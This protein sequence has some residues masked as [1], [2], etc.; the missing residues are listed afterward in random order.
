MTQDLSTRVRCGDFDLDLKAGELHSRG[1]SVRLQEQP[2]QVLRILIQSCGQV[3]SREEIKKKLWP[4]DTIVEFDNAINTAIKKL[5]LAFAD[6]NKEPKYIETVARRG[7]RFI[8]PLERLDSGSDDFVKAAFEPEAEPSALAGRIVSHYRVLGV[9]G[10][11]GMGIVYRAEDVKLDRAVAIKFLPEEM[12]NE[13]RAVERFEREAR[14]ASALDHP[15]ICSIYEFGEYQRQP[16]IVMPL[17]QGETL[18]DQLTAARITDNADRVRQAVSLAVQIAGGLE[19]AHENAIIHRDI[20][21]AN[22]FITTKGVAKILDFG[23]AKIVESS[24]E[25]VA[26]AEPGQSGAAAA[27]AA[28]ALDLTLSREGVAIGT[29]GYMSPEQVRGENL[30]ARTDLF[31]FGLVLYEMVTGQRTFSGE[32]V[33]EVREAILD[34]SPTPVRQLNPAISPPLEQIIN[35]TLEKKRELR[36]Q[37]AAE[38][39]GDLKSLETSDSARNEGV[40]RPRRPRPWK[41]MAAAALVLCAVIALVIYARSQRTPPLSEKDTVVIA[42]FANA[43]GEAVFDDSL[44]QAL[45]FQFDQSPYINVLSDRRISATLSQMERSPDQPLTAQIATEICQRT[46]S[47]AVLAGSI[48]RVENSY[49]IGLKALSCRTGHTLAAAEAQAKNRSEVLKAL[50]ITGDEMRSKLG[51]SLAS[52]SKFDQPLLEATT[53]S[54]EALKLLSQVKKFGSPTESIPY[55]KRA[56]ELDPNFALAYADLG[57]AYMNVGEAKLGAENIRKAYELRER[58]SQ[59]ERFYIEV[60]YYTLVTHELEKAEQSGKEWEQSYPEDW[61]PHNDLSI[62]YAQLG[63]LAEGVGEMREVIR[64]APDNSGAYGN[65]MGML[66]S[67]GRFAEAEECPSAGAR[68]QTGQS[69]SAAVQVRP[70][71]PAGRRDRHARAGAMG[72]G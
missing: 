8:M 33:E 17:L 47:K 29:A 13:P 37:S 63:K 49:D 40:S 28:R 1:R 45:A 64:I 53:S 44:R 20:K 56:L 32:T 34:R 50:G 55:V 67:L 14:A 24:D 27:G 39:L 25:V 43:T 42:D 72:S 68:P 19:A 51:E 18:R 10:G 31:S 36:Y 41:P 7:Y 60:T 22:I 58:T 65:L 35:R 38:L 59:R 62:I 9:V 66:T 15:N 30:D 61:R 54:L 71:L 5:R 57:A 26:G 6:S 16:F 46:G 70:C 11:G 4:N 52:V 2:L 12:G 69:L 3:I 23:L 48:G 21:P